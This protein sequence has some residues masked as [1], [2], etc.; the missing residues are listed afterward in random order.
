MKLT[1]R[2]FALLAG[3]AALPLLHGCAAVVVGGATTGVLS[4]LDRRTTGTQADDETTEWKA[5]KA[6]PAE[7]RN[8]SHVNFTSYNRR[9]LITGEVPSED[10]KTRI[11]EK[12]LTIDG[13]HGAFNELAIGPASSLANRSND[14]YITSKVKARF[15]DSRQ[16]SANHVKVVTEAGVCYLMGLVSEREANA[17]VQIA[18]TTAGVR[19]VVNVM[20][21]LSDADIQRLDSAVRSSSGSAPAAAPVENRR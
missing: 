1:A 11:G 5:D 13:V 16:L 19:K 3:L 12:V 18:R 21:V 7:A 20:E 6:I 17:A 10:V 4:V 14:S 8:Q 15:V 9:V 2:S